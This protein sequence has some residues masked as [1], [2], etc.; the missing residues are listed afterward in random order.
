[1]TNWASS[2]ALLDF[3]S[4]V[5]RVKLPSDV[6]RERIRK[7]AT[8]G[9]KWLVDCAELKHL[10]PQRSAWIASE[11]I[12]PRRVEQK[13]GDANNERGGRK[14]QTARGLGISVSTLV[15][16]EWITDTFFTW[17]RFFVEG[18]WAELPA[19]ME[20]IAERQKEKPFEP[21]ADLFLWYSELELKSWKK[22]VVLAALTFVNNAFVERI[23]AMLRNLFPECAASTLDDRTLT[24]LR[25][26]LLGEHLPKEDME[27]HRQ[28]CL[29]RNTK[30]PKLPKE[31]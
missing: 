8:S 18:E 15:R 14:E 17:R 27:Q 4:Q 29:K 13:N 6:E 3:A 12:L 23:F 21:G 16:R 2:V 25:L 30:V 10:L 22:L 20:A 5:G 24:A 19:D 31:N 11:A 1:M 9:L 26:R 28:E 7:E